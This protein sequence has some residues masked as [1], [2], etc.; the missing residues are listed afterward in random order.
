MEDN[1]TRGRPSN[2]SSSYISGDQHQLLRQ[3]TKNNANVHIYFSLPKKD[4]KHIYDNYVSRGTEWTNLKISVIRTRAKNFT[5]TKKE[6]NI[7]PYPQPEI[8][9][10]DFRIC[11]SRIFLCLYKWGQCMTYLTVWKQVFSMYL[12]QSIL[13]IK[14]WNEEILKTTFISKKKSWEFWHNQHMIK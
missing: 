1:Y 2:T 14:T 12:I 6:K 8:N 11:I 10:Q 4:M 9:I 13:Q 7:K 5:G 3:T